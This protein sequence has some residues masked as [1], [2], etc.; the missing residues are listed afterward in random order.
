MTLLY[1][2]DLL[3]LYASCTVHG[4]LISLYHFSIYSVDTFLYPYALP[5]AIYFLNFSQVFA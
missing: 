4:F 3:M 1:P 2:D 5:F